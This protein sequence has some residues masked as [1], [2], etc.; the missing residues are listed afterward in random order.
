MHDILQLMEYGAAGR[1]GAIVTSPVVVVRCTGLG[2]VMGERMMERT[3]KEKGLSSPPATHTS[4]QVDSST[5]DL[6]YFFVNDYSEHLCSLENITRE[7]E[8]NQ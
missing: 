4:V 3:A 2:R 8:E 1:H 6:S 5:H 7:V